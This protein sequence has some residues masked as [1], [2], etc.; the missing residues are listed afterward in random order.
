MRLFFVLAV[1]LRSAGGLRQSECT[2]GPK[3]LH[4]SQRACTDAVQQ[5]GL[6]GLQ[7]DEPAEYMQ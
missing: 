4:T 3:F 7:R 6:R 5:I 2:G 1:A